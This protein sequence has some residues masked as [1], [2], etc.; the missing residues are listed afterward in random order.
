MFINLKNF[1]HVYK[2][3]CWN[4]QKHLCFMLPFLSL[5]CFILTKSQLLPLFSWISKL[6][7]IWFP[8]SKE[9]CFHC[10]YTTHSSLNAFILTFLICVK[11]VI[12]FRPYLDKSVAETTVSIFHLFSWILPDPI[13]H[14]RA[15]KGLLLE[16]LQAGIVKGEVFYEVS[17]LLVPRD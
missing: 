17:L 14:T 9:P 10:I 6:P 5:F 3:F 16:Q 12:R 7:G 15:P 2:L 11:C 13:P 1:L 4:I 8:I